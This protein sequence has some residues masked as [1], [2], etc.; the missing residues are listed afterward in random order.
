MFSYRLLVPSYDGDAE[1]RPS[2]LAGPRARDARA[3]G[4]G[5]A[6]TV[7][8]S[9]VPRVVRIPCRSLA[10][11]SC[12]RSADGRASGRYRRSH[13]LG[14]PPLSLSVLLVGHGAGPAPRA[15]GPG[16]QSCP[17]SSPAAGMPGRCNSRGAYS[18][19]QATTPKKTSKAATTTMS[20]PVPPARRSAVTINVL[21]IAEAAPKSRRRGLGV[22]GHQRRRLKGGHRSSNG[23]C[24]SH[25]HQRQASHQSLTGRKG[26][27]NPSEGVLVEV[28]QWLSFDSPIDRTRGREPNSGLAAGP[29]TIPVGGQPVD[30]RLWAAHH[31]VART[32]LAH[33]L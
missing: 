1:G 17:S 16:A 28:L 9:P 22:V 29:V 18:E 33:V 32:N 4:E 6:S 25:P 10:H 26:C 7:H 8:R 24:R 11:T 21:P 5:R 15:P 20:V 31:G 14:H 2:V 19:V 13:S 12:R 23:T 27:P 3:D 30:R